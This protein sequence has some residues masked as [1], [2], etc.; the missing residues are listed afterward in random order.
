MNNRKR[1]DIELAEFI[2][3]TLTE[4]I[5]K[6]GRASL[7]V[8][9]GSTPIHL[10]KLLSHYEIAWDKVSITLVDERFVPDHHPDQNGA[11]VKN[12]LLQS[13]AAQAKFLPMVLDHKDSKNNLELVRAQMQIIKRP[14]SFVILGMGGDGHTAS[15]F[16]DALELDDAMNLSTS[17]DL[18]ITNPVRAPHERI[19]FTRRALLNTNHLILHCYGNEK[20]N[21]F[22]K[23]ADLNDYRPYPIEGFVHQNRVELKLFWTE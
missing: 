20:K 4:D 18:M 11:M 23:V 2:I 1:I 21:I 7:L 5:K 22:D 19:T 12:N 6:R 13:N 16:P 8:S 9:G 10:F 17:D 15:L 14:F 3:T